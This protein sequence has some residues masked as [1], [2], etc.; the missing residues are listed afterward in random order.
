M[1]RYR[2]LHTLNAFQAPEHDFLQQSAAIEN[3]NGIGFILL[4]S[5][6]GLRSVDAATT[7]NELPENKRYGTIVRSSI[8]TTRLLELDVRRCCF[9][10][11]MRFSWWTDERVPMKEQACS[12]C[13][14]M[15]ATYVHDEYGSEAAQ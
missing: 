13:D 7:T 10:M 4:S 8:E 11:M 14:A 5:N 12:R 1:K 3:E 15:R 9:M 2:N 6:R